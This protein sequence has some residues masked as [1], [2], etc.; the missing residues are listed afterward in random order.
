MFNL[1]TYEKKKLEYTKKQEENKVNK[2]RIKKRRQELI[3]LSKNYNNKM[4][5]FIF[6]M[7]E[8]PIIL[9]K[10]SIKKDVKNKTFVNKDFK[11]GEFKTDKQRLEIIEAYKNKLKLYDKKRKDIEKKGNILKIKNHRDLILVQPEMRFNSRTKLETIVEKIKNNDAVSGDKFNLLLSE[12][13]K[14]QNSIEVKRIN[15]YYFLLDKEDLKDKDIKKAIEFEKNIDQ[16]EYNNRYKLKNYIEWKYHQ[17]ITNNTNTVNKEKTV[18]N[19]SKS[20][21]LL[22]MIG[23]SDNQIESKNEYEILVKD[24]FKTHFKGASQFI[25]LLDLKDDN[26]FGTNNFIDY[27]DKFISS[28]RLR[29]YKGKKFEHFL[30]KKVNKFNSSRNKNFNKYY[31]M[32]RP[33]SVINFD[34][35]TNKINHLLFNKTYKKEYSLKDLSEYSKKKKLEMVDSM[36][37]EISKSISKDFLQKYNSINIYEN[38]YNL[39]GPKDILLNN[40]AKAKK[41]ENLNEKLSILSEHI[42]RE[43]RKIHDEKYR[44]FVKRFARS[45]AGFKNKEIQEDIDRQKIENKLD[46]VVIDGEIIQKKNIKK[47]AE[48]IFRKCNYNN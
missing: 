11:F 43:R 24:D 45:I 21:E 27:K 10:D 4:K 18:K 12:Y 26:E 29:N 42:N 20:K 23:K 16:C 8:K 48:S 28:I 1:Y 13:F 38:S 37:K 34:V 39:Y 36:N 44:L 35:D 7:C 15:E 2:I 30:P 17:N 9:H 46:Y 32:K 25:Q 14:K 19:L 6:S 40:F 31:E 33:S 41:D 3:K 22:Q 5:D 47:V